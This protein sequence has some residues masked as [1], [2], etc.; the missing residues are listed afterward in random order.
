MNEVCHSLW[1]ST[2]PLLVSSRYASEREPFFVFAHDTVSVE[3][4]CIPH[5]AD[6][7]WGL[8]T[9]HGYPSYSRDALTHRGEMVEQLGSSIALTNGSDSI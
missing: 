2:S 8:R 9:L 3:L 7:L 6:I 4:T 5:F 1:I